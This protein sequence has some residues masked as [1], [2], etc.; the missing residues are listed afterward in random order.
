MEEKKELKD[1]LDVLSEAITASLKEYAKPSLRERFTEQVRL[2]TRIGLKKLD[3]NSLA[4]GGLAQMQTVL[5]AFKDENVRLKATQCEQILQ[6]GLPYIEESRY[7]SGFREK[8][9]A[10]R[11]QLGGPVKGEL[12]KEI[13]NVIEQYEKPTGLLSRITSAFRNRFQPKREAATKKAIVELN[14]AIK[15][16]DFDGTAQAVATVAHNKSL[17][18]NFTGPLKSMLAAR[19]PSIDAKVAMGYTSAPVL[20]TGT[21]K[22]NQALGEEEIEEE[23][24]VDVDELFSERDELTDSNTTVEKDKEKIDNVTEKPIK[25]SA[26]KK[27]EQESQNESKTDKPS[28]RGT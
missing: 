27:N 18:P 10:A 22:I 20:D 7:F 16:G 19:W 9:I 2:R 12:E 3:D 5:L 14:L 24:D 25:K 4:A 28:T 13:N 1:P 23:D 8:I 21:A 6:A 26:S 11:L 15:G 17:S